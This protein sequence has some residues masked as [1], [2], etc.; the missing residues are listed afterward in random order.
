MWILGV[1]SSIAELQSI[2]PLRVGIDYGLCETEF[3]L[4][5]GNTID[6]YGRLGRFWNG[7]INW[8]GVRRRGT[9]RAHGERQLKLRDI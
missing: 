8:G 4:G 3:S 7:M 2:G 1:K 9:G 6:I 5:K